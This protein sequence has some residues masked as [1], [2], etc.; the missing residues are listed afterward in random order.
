MERVKPTR[1]HLDCETI[2][3]GFFLLQ[4]AKLRML[5]LYYIFFDNFCDVNK[6]KEIEMDTDSRYLDLAE[7]ILDEC[8]LPSK[9]AEWKGKQNKDCQENFRAHAKNNFS[10]VLA[11]LY[12]SSMTRENQD[13]SRRSSDALK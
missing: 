12:I 10:H 3:E 9:R 5:K 4:Y 8:I 13:C 2:I 1:E 7:E 6:F 11:A